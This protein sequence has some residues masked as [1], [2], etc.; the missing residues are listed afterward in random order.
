MTFIKHI[1]NL[2]TDNLRRVLY[3]AKRDDILGKSLRG[4]GFLA[5]G[6]FLENGGRFIRNI[7]LA[8]LLAPE[9]FGIMATI[10]ASIAVIE[11]I[12]QVGLRQS[13]IQNKKSIEEGFLNAVWWISSLRGLSLY[14]IAFFA[15]PHIAIYFN[16]SEATNILRIGFLVV[17]LNGLISPRVHLLEKALHFK[18]WIILM[19]GAAICG[20]IIAIAASFYLR[21]VWGL[22]LGYLSESFLRLILSFIFCPILPSFIISR[23]YMGHV[24]QFSKR[25]FGLPILMMIYAQLDI[26][27]IGK[28]LSVKALGMYVLVRSLADMP[29]TF[30]SKIVEPIILPVFSKHQD[31]ISE[32]KRL[33]L[34]ITKLSGLVL[35]PF[36]CFMIFFAKPVLRIVYGIDYAALAIPF[37]IMALSI[38]IIMM[39]TTI[40]QAY[41]ALGQPNL[42]RNASI[43][44]T[45][46]FIILIYPAIKILGLTGAALAALVAMVILISVQLLYA[47]R[48]FR[49]SVGEYLMTW[50]PGF[51]SALIIAIPGILLN[52]FFNIQGILF[53][54]IGMV[55]CLA[56][57]SYSAIR[58]MLNSH[59]RN[60]LFSLVDSA[61]GSNAK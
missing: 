51:H 32:I 1:I 20:V 36:S 48:I 16:Q 39:A 17:L 54:L 4:G 21:S 34:L 61:R 29:G 8:R 45:L 22:V 55:L 5:A 12:T 37:A 2:I 40:V 18:K 38:L 59:N 19:Q 50:L 11:A 49:F 43:A 7:V 23:E 24:I 35:I 28:L 3:S 13:T 14:A 25:M 44:R 41:F 31:N 42:H 46:I 58:I 27:I 6:S 33:I 56:A 26:Y 47:R 57:W 52:V 15:A 53:F 9:A 60:N 10:T 30:F